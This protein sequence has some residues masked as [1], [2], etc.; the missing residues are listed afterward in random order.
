M[1]TIMPENSI[2]L[3]KIARDISRLQRLQKERGIIFAHVAMAY[4]EVI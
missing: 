4:F 2:K 1:D 3:I